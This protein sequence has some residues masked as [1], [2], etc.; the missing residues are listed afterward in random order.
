LALV[1]ALGPGCARERT[2]PAE[3]LRLADRAAG[4]GAPTLYTLAD[5]TRPVLAPPPERRLRLTVPSGLDETF[6][7]PLPGTETDDGGDLVVTGTY[8]RTKPLY[9]LAPQLLAVARDD[10][11]GRTATLALPPLAR[12]SGPATT[13]TLT[14]TAAPA[15]AAAETR[16]DG[17][18][19]PAAAE[20]RFAFALSEAAAVPGAAPV[21]FDVAA[22]AGDGAEHALWSATLRPEH[23]RSRRW[24]EAAV[25]LA[26]LAGRE[27]DLLF[28][29]RAAGTG[30]PL[31]VPL[32]GDPTIVHPAPRPPERRNVVLISIDTLRA[33]RVG[34]YGSYRPTT[35]AIDALAA[36]SVIFTDAWAPWPETSGSHMSLFTSRYPSEHGVTSFVTAPP[37]A[38]E[39]LAERLRREGW[40][41]RA[42]T[43]NGGVWAHAGFARGFNA[44]GERRSPDFVYRGEAA[45]TFA[46]ATRWVEA[47]AARTF[48]LFVHTYQVHAPYAPP[49]GYQTLFA[50]IAGREPRPFVAQALAYDR[51]TRFTDDQIG[52]FVA[53]LRRLGLAER[54]ILVLTSDH[55]EEF[56][57]HG[58]IGHGRTLHREVLH[59]P[60]VLWAPGLLAPA[61]VAA[62]ASLLDVAPTLLD[63]LGLAA[64]P[65]HRG[66]SLR[67][68]LRGEAPLDR[69][70][71]AEVDRVEGGTR[72]HQVAVRQAG[73]TA[74]T[75]LARD[76]TRC[77]GADDPGERRSADACPDLVALLEAHRLAMQAA[78]ALEV[79]T[80]DPRLVEKMRALGY[81]D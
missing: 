44:Y 28:R 3:G 10:A 67:R 41:T 72:Y 56:G 48:F 5:E 71:L 79:E 57:E 69:P 16:V 74:I 62:P 59:V 34:V 23:P 68:A 55:G 15:G 36:E 7:F 29:A 25:P 78:G 65:S 18:A 61:R 14:L 17:V 32:W 77:Y 52:P 6:T 26:T 63:L 33:D 31:V 47:N 35:P 39:L 13:L 22:R 54:T 60:L 76:A 75:D 27:V 21:A 81:L 8:Q 53:A 58:G 40:L 19:V 80:I 24:R 51:E 38:L 64:D 4:A 70:I 37:P 1:A 46:D 30:R 66:T 42:F 11:G 50:D 20:L 12:G 9:P 43:E 45:A 73:R 49:P 2:A